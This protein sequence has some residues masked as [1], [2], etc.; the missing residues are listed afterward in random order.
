MPFVGYLCIFG[1]GIYFEV[2]TV[3]LL[4][5]QVFLDF[6]L[7]RLLNSNGGFEGLHGQAVQEVS[8][9]CLTSVTIYQWTHRK[10]HRSI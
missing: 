6:T 7:C 2:F 3:L 10:H 1:K 5:V 9:V 8:S 4:K